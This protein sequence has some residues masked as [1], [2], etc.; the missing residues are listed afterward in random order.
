MKPYPAYK[1]PSLP[2][3]ERIPTGWNA[4]P[5]IALFDERIERGFQDR[6]LL[7]VTITRGVIRQTELEDNRDGSNEDKWAYKRVCP[8]DLAYNKM[9]MWQGAVG[10]SQFEG[11][12]SP[13]YIVLKPKRRLNAKFFHYLFRTPLYIKES[14]R[15]SYGI[16]DDM[17]SLR[18]FD[19]KRMWSILPPEQE[20]DAIV[21]FLE[22]KDRD[23]QTFIAN[24][25]RMIELLKEQKAALIN[26]AVTRGLN[27][28]APIQPSGIPWLGDIPAHWEIKRMKRIGRIRY[29]LGQPPRLK[30][31]GIPMLRATNID[32]GEILEKDLLHVDPDD[33]P[34]DRNPFLR[35]GEILV[36]RSG[37]L[38]ADSAIVPSRFAGALAG[39][40]MVLTA[41][42]AD[43]SFVSYALLSDY[44]QSKQLHLLKLR[45]AQA[46]LNT[47]ELGGALVL[48]PK[49]IEEQKLIASFL[50]VQ[51]GQIAHAID[52]AEREI[53]LMEEYRTA[54]IAAAVTGKMD[55]RQATVPEPN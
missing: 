50:S 19:F 18:Y 44:L 40:D 41:T 30:D 22:A 2:W 27:P 1:N 16:C 55:V 13:A 12:V 15:N 35:Q 32:C 9:R 45:A 46:H 6:E 43:A 28:K 42:K 17:L 23:I 29:G 26:R 36:V 48:L 3:A 54:L 34:R 39:Y 25:R 49:S 11:I 5:N 33:I 7:A 52:T 37:A 53:A 8:G 31:D 14:Y 10:Y 38:T 20:Q 21:D 4:F 24:K 47:E 51:K